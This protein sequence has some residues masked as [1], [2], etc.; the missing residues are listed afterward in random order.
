M[1]FMNWYNNRE[2]RQDYLCDI[3]DA[4]RGKNPFLWAKTQYEPCAWDLPVH[5]RWVVCNESITQTTKKMIEKC[6]LIY[7]LFP[8]LRYM[9]K[10]N[11]Y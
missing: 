4:R 11:L 10:L 6:L 5:T 9:K 8:N 3:T 1:D 7:L 2:D